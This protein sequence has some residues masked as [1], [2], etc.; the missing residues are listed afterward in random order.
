MIGAKLNKIELSNYDPSWIKK[1]NEEVTQLKVLLKGFSYSFEHIG[2]TSIPGCVARPSIDIL[3]MVD[4]A[5]DIVSV[6]NRL[7]HESGIVYIPKESGVNF[8]KL[9]KTD[10]N[11]FYYNYYVVGKSSKAAHSFLL[12]K[13]YLIHNPNEVRNYNA[14][15][16]DLKNKYEEK[17]HLYQ[18]MKLKYIY[19]LLE[20]IRNL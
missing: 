13:Y 7:L 11:K 10:Y 2:S 3:I 9:G 14:V 16:V 12:F 1:F 4:S 8:L 6:K 19:E 20:Q 18:K 15:K 5:N 17:P